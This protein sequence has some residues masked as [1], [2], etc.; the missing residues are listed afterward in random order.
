MT[1]KMP[2]NMLVVP[3]CFFGRVEVSIKMPDNQIYWIDGDGHVHTFDHRGR[4][5][6]R[7]M[8]EVADDYG[9]AGEE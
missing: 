6:D 5:V 4:L 7:E 8:P 2:R 3:P 1:D 9:E